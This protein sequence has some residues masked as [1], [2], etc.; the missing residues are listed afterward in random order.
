VAVHRAVAYFFREA[1]LNLARSW[2]I[3]LVAVSTIA[4]S[5]FVGGALL[6]LTSNIGDLVDEWG[7]GAKVIVY[8]HADVTPETASPLHAQLLR[9]R[10]ASA[11]QT[12]TAAEARRRFER[13]FPSVAD[14]VQGWEEEPLPASFEV[15]FEPRGVAEAELEAWLSALRA[16]PQVAMVDDD[17]DW[18]R[19]LEGV[20][21]LVRGLGLALVAV[22]LLC[23]TF[24]IASVIRL[25]A[26]LYR[27]EI[28]IM[29]LVGATEL[30]IRAPFYVEGLLQG[31]L[32]GGLAVGALYAAY[33]ALAPQAPAAWL[34]G[35]L[36]GSFL[37]AGQQT[38]LV[39]L[40]AASGLAGAVASL[41]REEV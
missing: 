28:G 39:V 37:A 40:G 31:T 3:S 38:L 25:T 8:L 41:R 27:D 11:V 17:R 33:L 15:S 16:H 22:L 36:T 20:L 18:V 24:T 30:F 23:A 5:L 19:Q 10:W 2:K 13:Y 9:T 35:A 6:L 32:G 21:R 14:L 7:R 29:R 26:Y 1:A 12:V 4:V 34:G